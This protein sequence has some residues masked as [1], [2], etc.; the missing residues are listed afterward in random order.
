MQLTVESG[1]V[2]TVGTDPGRKALAYAREIDVYLIRATNYDDHGYPIRTRIGV[3]RS[4]TLTQMRT[5][6]DDL[7]SDPFFAGVRLHTH[8]IDEAVAT[9]PVREIIRRSKV[10][11]VRVIVAFV[12][13]QSNQ[14]P[15]SRDLAARFLPHGIPVLIGGFHVSGTLAMITLTRELR[16]ALCDGI[17]LVA[18]EVE[19]GRLPRIIEDVVT[20]EAHPLY[21]FLE[22]TP[23]LE[24]APT[25]RLTPKDFRSFASPFSTLD[26]GRGCP[27]TCK[28]CTIINVQGNT[29]RFRD[30]EHVIDFVRRGYHDAGVTHCFFTDDNL[31]RNPRWP[32]LFD[33]LTHLRE[34]EHIPFTFMMQADLAARKMKG[35]FFERAARAGCDQVF[36][37]VESVS[38]ENLRAQGK[39]QNQVRGYHDLVSYLQSLGMSCHAGYILGLPF[40]TPESIRHDIETLKEVGFDL[41][42]FYILTAL[43]GS[44]DHQTWHRNR[45]PL[46]PDLNLYDSAHITVK[47]ER[48]TGEELMQSY[49]DAWTQL[50]T[51]DYMVQVMRH[52][53]KTPRYWGQLSTLAWYLYA[54]LVEGLHPMN[55]GF[56]RI[57][58]RRD[59]RP[60]MP[61][62]SLPVFLVREALDLLRRGRVLMRL[63]RQFEEVWLRS[64]PKSRLE[65]ELEALLAKT[66]QDVVDWQGVRTRELVAFYRELAEKVPELRTL[67]TTRLSVWLRKHNPFIA[68]SRAHVDRIWREWYRHVLNPLRWVEVWV[69]EATLAV[70]FLSSFLQFGK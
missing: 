56:W 36:M 5:L 30:P 48:M 67:N 38:Q 70:R 20:G 62:E 2:P 44:E 31:A 57:R 46:E 16:D 50:Y 11:G 33:G 64:R 25:P 18:G 3:I 58:S 14:F 4:N 42:S 28:F 49:R 32:E 66:K 35:N 29:M 24:R 19:E 6:T 17:I 13:V 21:N 39:Y 26:T 53:R 59:R 41:V 52:W 60:G 51:T 68:S 7:R 8:P 65:E 9:V 34:Q 61:R 23:S 45:V 54:P 22:R 27:F 55:C 1:A 10:P 12:G 40:D 69:F 47:P 63:L 43:P 37:G 15:R